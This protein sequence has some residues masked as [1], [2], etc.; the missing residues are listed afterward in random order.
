MGKE[1][2]ESVKT[3]SGFLR[4]RMSFRVNV[5][6][7][8][9]HYLGIDLSRRNIRVAKHFLNRTQVRSVFQQVCSKGVAQG[10]GG[11]IF[12]D[13]RL[14]LIKLDDFPKSPDGT[15]ACRSD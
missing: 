2:P 3:D 4:S 12:F 14:I 10:M 6:Q 11:N 8:L 7:F 13:A 9:T 1:K 15:Y 5:F